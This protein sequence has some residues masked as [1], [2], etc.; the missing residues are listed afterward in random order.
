MEDYYYVVVTVN[1]LQ[2]EVQFTLNDTFEIFKYKILKNSSIKYENY[3]DYHLYNISK[4]ILLDYDK[5]VKITTI[6]SGDNLYN[7]DEITFNLNNNK[8]QEKKTYLQHILKYFKCCKT[9][10]Y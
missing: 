6:L 8:R 1:G 10:L 9:K 3:D 5:S 4:P 2:R 7:G